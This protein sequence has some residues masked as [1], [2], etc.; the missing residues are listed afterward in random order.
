[1]EVILVDSASADN[2]KRIM[3]EFASEDTQFKRVAIYDNPQRKQACGW[4][5]AIKNAKGDAIIRVDGHARIPNDF[6]KKNVECLN[7]GEYVCGGPR[8]NITLQNGK[9]KDMLL[10][11]ESSMFGSSIAPYRRKDEYRKYVKSIFHGAYRRE[12]FQLIGGF[13]EELGR[14]EDN[15]LHYRIRKAGYKI[16]YDPLIIS[17]QYV[18]SSWK[19]MVKQKYGNGYWIG[20]TTGICMGC[21]SIYHFIPIT[22]VLTLFMGILFGMTVSWLPLIGILSVYAVFGISAVLSAFKEKGKNY[23]FILMPAIFLSLHI[24]YGIGTIVGLMDM[25]IRKCRCK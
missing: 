13:N 14:T 15:E 19:G 8:P 1:M 24:S 10:A 23:V 18:R 6:V 2:T 22:F 25:L 3:T 5:I 20:R 17:F 11:V 12:I 16:C 4:N 9:W 21:L 7:S